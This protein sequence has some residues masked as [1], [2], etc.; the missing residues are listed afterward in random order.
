MATKKTKVY[1]LQ[2]IRDIVDM[3]NKDN[4]DFVAVNLAAFISFVHTAKKNL[5]KKEFENI[6]LADISFIDDGKAQVIISNADGEKIVITEKS[7]DK[8]P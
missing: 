4:L 8:Q 2:T 3:I 7:I 5:S 1:K 6:R